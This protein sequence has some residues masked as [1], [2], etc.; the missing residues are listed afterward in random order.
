M[1]QVKTLI[2]FLV[3]CTSAA[4]SQNKPAT[5][6]Q[7]QKSESVKKADQILLQAKQA[8]S[9]KTKISDIKALSISTTITQQL[10]FAGKKID[11]TVEEVYNFDLT[12]KIRYNSVGDYT[13][14]KAVTATILNGEKFSS[15]VDV[16][17]DG[18]LIN[19]GAN[20]SQ[21]S[22]ISNLKRG[23]FLLVFPITLDSSWYMPLEFNYVGIAESNDGKAE[24]IEAVSQNKAKYR[25]FFDTE[26]YLLLMMTES[27]T[28]ENN[29]QHE[30]KFF[31]SDYQEKGGLLVA[32]KIIIERNGEV[33]EEKQ[34]KDVKINPNFKS[35]MFEVK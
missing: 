4:F 8:K 14:N 25:L 24:V 7:S 30:N 31:F 17:V 13:T 16:F 26:T 20:V 9:K 18:K 33:D 34:I 6:I 32:T 19:V 3:I 5:S 28:G 29:K 1:K 21:K 12:D 23:T 35:D 11:G 27:W 2:L 10:T 15:K 22:Q